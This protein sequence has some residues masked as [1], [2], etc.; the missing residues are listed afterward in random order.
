MKKIIVLLLAVLLMVSLVSCGNSELKA[1]AKEIEEITGEKTTVEDVKEAIEELE[2]LSGEKV[3][4][5][6]VVEF[7]RDMYELANIFE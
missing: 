2:A 6:D 7:T 5:E 1:A 4:A 3:T